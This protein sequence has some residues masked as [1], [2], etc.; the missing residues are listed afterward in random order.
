MADRDDDVVCAVS[1][2]Q[3]DEPDVLLWFGKGKVVI[4]RHCW[5]A[6][7]AGLQIAAL[8]HLDVSRAYGKPKRPLS[9][10]DTRASQERVSVPCG[11]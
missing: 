3:I 8:R 5:L 6:L 7:E 4:R 2:E 11:D 1:W 10:E 9:V